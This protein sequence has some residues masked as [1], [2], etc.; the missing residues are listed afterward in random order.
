MLIK[1]RFE[2]SPVLWTTGGTS[3]DA[4]AVRAILDA[5]AGPDR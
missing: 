1:I 3:P 5:F 4:I 2:R